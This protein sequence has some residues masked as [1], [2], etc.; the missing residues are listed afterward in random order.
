[1]KSEPDAESVRLTKDQ[2]Q[3]N[4]DGVRPGMRRCSDK[5]HRGNPWLPEVF[6]RSKTG[7]QLVGTCQTCRSISHQNQNRWNARKRSKLV[8]NIGAKIAKEKVEEELHPGLR[9][10]TAPKHQGDRWVPLAECVSTNGRILKTCQ[11]CRAS[12]NSKRDNRSRGK[13]NHTKK[14]DVEGDQ[15]QHS[16]EIQELIDTLET[17]GTQ[18]TGDPKEEADSFP[19][20]AASMHFGK[21]E[22]TSK[23][24]PH[25]SDHWMPESSFLSPDGKSFEAC[26]ECRARALQRSQRVGAR[27][28][29]L[30]CEHAQHEGDF[31]VPEREFETVLGTVYKH[32]EKCREIDNAKYRAR[33][34]ASKSQECPVSNQSLPKLRRLNVVYRMA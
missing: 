18:E 13:A 26:H 21:R 12:Y 33:T 32:C 15:I 3:S 22:C 17:V 8:D 31:W 30:Y 11:Q 6:F 4:D 23:Y 14:M 1:M 2:D 9:L 25:R 19:A 34:T 16:T 24:H 29:M 10:C 7:R 28:G 20:V 27:P 5:G